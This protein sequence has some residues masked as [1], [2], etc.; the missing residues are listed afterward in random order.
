MGL[1]N[2]LGK[3]FDVATKLADS[4]AAR[5]G[6]PD[7]PSVQEYANM[8]NEKYERWLR[9]TSLSE[10]KEGLANGKYRI[11]TDKKN[12]YQRERELE[13]LIERRGGR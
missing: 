2:V 13:E 4:A 9:R 7:D 10:L 3:A 12:N 6:D 11:S 8:M 1:W 5:S